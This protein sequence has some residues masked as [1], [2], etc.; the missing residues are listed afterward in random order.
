VASK[1]DVKLASELKD[2]TETRIELEKQIVE[3]K[4]KMGSE[5]KKSIENIKKLVSL[6]ALRMDSVEK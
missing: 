2:L 3:Q 6:E 4:I 5:D 1:E